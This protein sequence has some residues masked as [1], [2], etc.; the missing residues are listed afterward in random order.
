MCV[1]EAADILLIFPVRL[2]RATFRS[3]PLPAPSP[4]T[5][6]P[7]ST[8]AVPTATLPVP[9]ILSFRVVVVVVVITPGREE[10]DGRDFLPVR[11]P[12]AVANDVFVFTPIAPD[13][14]R[15][16]HAVRPKRKKTQ[17]TTR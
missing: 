15:P 17:T 5:D 2:R 3:P 4:P 9:A 13:C 8:R 10:D 16:T 12:A 6:R 14:H 11:P 7:D 1:C